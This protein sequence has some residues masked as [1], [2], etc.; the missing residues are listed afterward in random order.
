MLRHPGGMLLVAGGCFVALAAAAAFSVAIP[1]DAA[2]RGALLALATPPVVGAM[3]IVTRLGHAWFLVPATLAL[4][5]VFPATRKRWPLW[6]GLMIV[7]G[8]AEPALKP[9]VQRPRPEDPSHGFPSGHATAAAAFFSAVIYLAGALAPPK[10]TVARAVAALAI[11]AV[12]VSRVTLRAHWPSDVLGGIALGMALAA[13][14]AL[15][16]DRRG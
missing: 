11:V 9:L 10:R 14:A 13:A 8:L 12:G 4:F 2:V 5:V 3:R 6:L 1:A 15:V 7:A 16:A